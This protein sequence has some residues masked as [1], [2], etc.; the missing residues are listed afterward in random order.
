MEEE[1]IDTDNAF[2]ELDVAKLT[3]VA[4][5]TVAVITDLL[6]IEQVATLATAVCVLHGERAIEF[7][8]LA[9]QASVSIIKHM[10]EQENV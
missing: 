2:Q 8:E 6:P 9:K 1:T 7:F 4:D 10:K 5:E 3:L